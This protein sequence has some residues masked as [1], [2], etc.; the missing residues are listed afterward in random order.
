VPFFN[1]A[2]RHEGAWGSGGIAPR[3]LY[4][5]TRWRWVVSCTPRL[6]YLQ[7]KNPWYPSDRRLGGPQSRSGYGG[8]EKNSQV[9][10]GLGLPIIQFSAQRCI[11][12][13]SRLRPI[14]FG[15]KKARVGGRKHLNFENRITCGPIKGVI[16][17]ITTW[18]VVSDLKYCRLWSDTVSIHIR[19]CIQKCPDCLPGART[20]NDTA[21]CH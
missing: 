6:I 4:L 21:L 18:N 14:T 1:W 13:L 19:E 8:D 9:L 16:P 3:I 10:L 20:A 2:Q 12:E 15:V 7:G 11:T 17:L 5:G